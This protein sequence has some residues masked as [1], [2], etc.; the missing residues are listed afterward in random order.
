MNFKQYQNSTILTIISPFWYFFSQT[1]YFQILY[2]LIAEQYKPN[3]SYIAQ[4]DI[5]FFRIAIVNLMFVLGLKNK[6]TFQVSQL[7]FLSSR[8]STF[9]I[10]IL[11][12]VFYFVSSKKLAKL[13]IWT[14]KTKTRKYIFCGYESFTFVHKL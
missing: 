3:K 2:F 9:F 12:W 5:N 6:Y 7:N 13:Y 14:T 8:F 10:S 11:D 1:F 4:Y